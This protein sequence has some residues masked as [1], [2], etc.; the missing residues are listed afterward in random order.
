MISEIREYYSSNSW[1][2]KIIRIIRGSLA[3]NLLYI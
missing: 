3:F 2:M 1:I